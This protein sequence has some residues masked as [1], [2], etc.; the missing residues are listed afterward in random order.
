[1]VYQQLLTYS[2]DT[3]EFHFLSPGQY[4]DHYQG[5]PFPELSRL[6]SDYS[7]THPQNPLLLE[8][9][10]RASGQILLNPKPVNFPALGPGD[11][12]IIMAFTHVSRIV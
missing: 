12:L 2:E 9:T 5:K 4:P 3:N 11:A 10:K 7:A 6:I 1:M 8:G